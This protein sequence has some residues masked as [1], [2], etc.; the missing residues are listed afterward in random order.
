MIIRKQTK[1]KWQFK[2]NSV[3]NNKK[4]GYCDYFSFPPSVIIHKTVLLVL[5]WWKNVVVKVV[6]SL[7]NSLNLEHQAKLRGGEGG[8][9]DTT[10]SFH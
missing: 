6:V 5:I 9:K 1:R 7:C 4:A 10:W 2:I 3:L 8:G